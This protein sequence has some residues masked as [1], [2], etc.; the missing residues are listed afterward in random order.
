MNDWFANY[1]QKFS[2]HWICKKEKCGFVRCHFVLWICHNLLTVCSNFLRAESA[3]KMWFCSLPFCSLNLSRFVNCMQ[4]F[5]VHWI[6]VRKIQPYSLPF[7]SLNL[8]RTTEASSL[9]PRHPLTSC[10]YRLPSS[11]YPVSLGY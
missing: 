1:T 7:C 9:L 10:L 4:K 2:A 6:C 8:S 3:R 5:S 11:L